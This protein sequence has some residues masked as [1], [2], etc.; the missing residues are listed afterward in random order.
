[1]ARPKIYHINLTDEELMFI[2]SILRKVPVV[3]LHS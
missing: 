1:M 2:K 3:Y